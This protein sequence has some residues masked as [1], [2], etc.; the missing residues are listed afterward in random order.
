MADEILKDLKN[1]RVSG[2]SELTAKGRGL[3]R[4]KCAE[5]ME[6]GELRK[7]YLQSLILWADNYA[8]YWTLRKEVED[9]G[10]TFKTVNKHGDN[11]ISANP[12]VKMMMDAQKMANNI[13]AE[14]G[15]TLKQAKKLGKTEKKEKDPLQTFYENE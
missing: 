9:E 15:A 1:I 8:R 13:M 6:S 11:V 5:L 12:K 7:S 3:Y 4:A 2:Y 14:F 10:S